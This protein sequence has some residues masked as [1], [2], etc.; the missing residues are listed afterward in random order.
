MYSCGFSMCLTGQGS[1]KGKNKGKAKES[2]PVLQLMPFVPLGTAC[3]EPSAPPLPTGDDHAMPDAD[4][5]K[6]K[7]LT[8]EEEMERAE[9]WI[10][11]LTAADGETSIVLVQCTLR[12]KSVIVLLFSVTCSCL[13]YRYALQ[14]VLLCLYWPQSHAALPNSCSI[15]LV[16]C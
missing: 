16:T 4:D 9:K 13:D 15:F 6:R 7:R 8:K 2:P 10:E 5:G 12:P 11:E 14:L 1:G 3:Y